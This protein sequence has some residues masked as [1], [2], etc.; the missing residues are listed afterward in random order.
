MTRAS[1]RGWLK[2]LAEPDA[3]NK[4]IHEQNREMG[5]DVLEFGAADLKPLCLSK[6]FAEDRFGE[7]T[8]IRWQALVD[9]L[10]EIGSLKA[11]DVV[12]SDAFTTKFLKAAN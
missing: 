5:L 1:I 12:A 10:V 3:T 8:A 11:G 9:Q 4:Y 7:M 2:Y 6:D